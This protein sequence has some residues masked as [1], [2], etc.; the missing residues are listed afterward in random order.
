MNSE[1]IKW[2]KSRILELFAIENPIVQ[3]GMV[4]VSG[5]K[6]AAAAANTGCLGL[7]GA[8][9]MYPDL[10][11][12]QINKAHALTQKPF[13]VNIPLLY[14]KT[15][16]QIKV[17]LHAGVKIF[18]TSAGSPKKWTPFLKKEGCTVVHVVSSPEFAQ[19]SQDAGVDAVVVEGF[20]A[21]GHN[22]RDEITSLVLLQQLQNKLEIPFIIAGG[23]ATGSSI[24]GALAMG[25]EGVQI[26]TAFAATVESSAH[27]NFKQAM[28][29]AQYNSTFLRMKKL[30]P[31]RLLENDF[32][33]KVAQAENIC[34]SNEELLKIL[35][36]GRA[37]EGMLNGN[38]QEGELEIGQ[39]VS[40]IKEIISCAN[41]VHKLKM[42]YLE[43]RMRI[44]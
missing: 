4:W 19:K 6:L 23:F 37:K 38:L 18:F 40:E 11:K 41:L 2:P 17:A 28:C 26:G 35:G 42:E 20:E 9:S 7:I 8:G 21:G 27:D 3:A 16:E 32:A 34:A 24:L 30:V 1:L 15:E 39:I 14:D 22:G 12:E 36:K 31:V 29:N 25:A 5:G 43:A 33:Q 10:L 44:L 13:G